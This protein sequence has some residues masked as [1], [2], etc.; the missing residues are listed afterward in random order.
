VSF[1]PV[2]GVWKLGF[3]RMRQSVCRQSR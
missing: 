3:F 1:S 2:N